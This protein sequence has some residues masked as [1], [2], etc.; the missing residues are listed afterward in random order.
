MTNFNFNDITR[1]IA[2]M[3][4]G[5]VFLFSL[6]GCSDNYVPGDDSKGK[7]VFLSAAVT[8]RGVAGS[9]NTNEEDK[10]K[11][12][13]LVIC[14][15]GSGNVIYN[16]KH[17][18]SDFVGQTEGQTQVWHSPFK[19]EEGQRDFFFIANED[20]W[21][22]GTA[23]STLTNRAQLFNDPAFTQIAYVPGY[24]PNAAKSMLMTQAYRN[25]NV[26]AMRNGKG[27]TASDPQH[28]E[29][30]GDEQVELIRT[31]SKVKLT[32]KNT[33][34]VIDN[35]G[36]TFVGKALHFKN[37]NPF[38][39]LQVVNIPK[40]FSLFVNPF[41]H[42]K[43]G[44]A[45][46]SFPGYPATGEY[47]TTF[48]SASDLQEA[49]DVETSTSP[50]LTNCETQFIAPSLP[51]GSPPGTQPIYYDYITTIYL[52]EYL[53]PY[54]A[55]DPTVDPSDPKKARYVTGAPSFHLDNF[56]QT[57]YKNSFWQSSF[58]ENRQEVRHTPTPLYYELPNQ[59][60]YS[61][62]SLVRNN[63][64]NVEAQE[65]ARLTLK[66]KIEDWCAGKM[67]RVYAGLGFNVVVDDPKFD[68]G[69]QSLIHILAADRN[70]GQM[71]IVEL[72]PLI[73]GAQFNVTGGTPPI[74]PTFKFGGTHKDWQEEGTA[75][76]QLPSTPAAGTP[77]FKI[78]Y[79]GK[80]IYTVNCE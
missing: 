79:N 64:Y 61:L 11:T 75:T 72:E 73:T 17:P 55:A 49:T 2:G 10:V 68:N 53:R 36:G 47:S 26:Q 4:A 3:A 78:K 70:V 7:E 74:Q 77:L 56:T 40:Y 19:V 52:P 35:G 54:N 8:I 21:N 66:Y 50:L 22:L 46:Y 23:F 20:D 62:Y 43:P 33:V 76:L 71:G 1:R 5:T 80:V 67:G 37:L 51:S 31:L 58:T 30:E 27:Q 39:R 41:F 63:A 29:A 25:V 18:V 60:N 16:V 42:T 45:S 15:S 24:K 34:E 38:R 44:D 13:R 59:A 12:I 28:F 6:A 65:G 32:L 69:N 48:Y 9:I 14:E 57:Y